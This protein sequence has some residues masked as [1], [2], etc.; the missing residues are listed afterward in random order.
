[1]GTMRVTGGGKEILMS[2]VGLCGMEIPPSGASD[3]SKNLYLSIGIG[4]STKG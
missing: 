4:L 2:G 3:M 1:M